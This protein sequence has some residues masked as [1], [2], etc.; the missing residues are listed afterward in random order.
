MAADEAALLVAVFA[1]PAGVIQTVEDGSRISDGRCTRNA[2]RPP[3]LK[4]AEY[5]PE[6]GNDAG[7]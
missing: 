2:A 3:E 5:S 1:S 7:N 4:I 6:T